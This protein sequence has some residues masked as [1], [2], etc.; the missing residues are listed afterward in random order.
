MGGDLLGDRMKE[1][2]K[3][4]GGQ[5]FFPLLPTFARLDGK[6]F[7]KWTK[8]LEK[9]YDERF[10]RLMEKLTAILLKETNAN[11]AY[12]QS[13]EITLVWYSTDY[14][15]QIFFD[16]KIQKMNSVLA[17]MCTAHFNI[18]ANSYFEEPRK[19]ALFDCRVWQVPTLQ[20]A[21]H[22]FL[23]RELD[24]VRNSIQSLARTYYSH[25]Q[26]NKKSSSQLQDMIHE[27]ND[28]WNN[29]PSYFK[30][31][32]YV[33]RKKILRSFTEQEIEKLPA[34]HNARNN[35]DLQ[36]ERT[37]IEKIEMPP[38]SQIKNPVEVILMGA[39]PIC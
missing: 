5:R 35:P 8:D 28:N 24:A 23:W 27:K 37:S 36:I 18:L 21:V 17:S 26:C 16:G 32:T 3:I 39:E 15:S 6:C 20:E 10:C 14:K 9:P 33:Q 25:K 1:Y 4:Y 31:G 38:L 7:S 19:I 29:Y 12:T 30:R 11:M 22:V 2:E 13:D 34:K